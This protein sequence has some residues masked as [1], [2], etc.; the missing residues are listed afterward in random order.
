[1]ALTYVNQIG[2]VDGII[3]AAPTTMIPE[4]GIVWSRDIL[5]DRMGTLRRRGPLTDIN[6]ASLEENEYIAGAVST[7]DPQGEWRMAA[8][9][10]RGVATNGVIRFYNSSGAG[11][12]A[13]TL[14]VNLP[15]G[16]YRADNTVEQNTTER[17]ENPMTHVIGH[18]SLGS[19][20][21]LSVFTSYGLPVDGLNYDRFQSLFYW[22]GGA[23]VDCKTE[24]ANCRVGIEEVEAASA[25]PNNR[26]FTRVFT[27]NTSGQSITLST[28]GRLTPGMFVF[29]DDDNAPGQCIG[30]IKSVE[31]NDPAAPTGFTL[32]NRPM[33]AHR[34]SLNTASR[35]EY[36][37]SELASLKLH[38]RNVRGYMP[39]HGRGLISVSAG[40]VVTGGAE[41]TSTEGHFGA[42]RLNEGDVFVYRNSDMACIGKI[43]STKPISNE[44][45]QL[46]FETKLALNSDEYLAVRRRTSDNAS[47]DGSTEPAKFYQSRISG[48]TG[49]VATKRTPAD[50]P[51]VFTATY[52]GFQWYGSLGQKGHENQIAFSS[53]HN[54]EA[55]DLSPDA[56]DTIVIPGMNVMRGIATSSSGLVIFMGDKVYILRG[57]DRSNFSLEVL[58]PEGC[59]SASS[60][61]E[62]GGGVMWA[63]RAGILYFDGSSVRNLTADNWG[64]YYYD[65]V[66]GFD[67]NNDRC[68]SFLYKNY[69]FV[70][71]TRWSSSYSYRRKE[72]QYVNVAAGDTFDSIIVDGVTYTEDDYKRVCTWDDLVQKRYAITWKRIRNTIPFLTFAIYLP[73]G[74]ITALSNFS[75]SGAVFNDAV[76]ATTGAQ[77][78]FSKSWVAINAAK[79][80]NSAFVADRLPNIVTSVSKSDTTVT[81]TLDSNYDSDNADPFTASGSE[82]P[83]FQVGTIVDLYDRDDNPIVQAV[84]TG[85]NQSTNQVTYTL[86]SGAVP[87]GVVS[88]GRAEYRVT[89]SGRWVDIDSM[90]DISTNGTDDIIATTSSIPGPDWFLQ[91][92]CYTVGDPVIKKWFQRFMLSMLIQAGSVRVDMID[93]ENNDY[94]SS[95]LR[96]RNWVQFSEVVYKWSY[97]E[98]TLFKAITDLDDPPWAAVESLGETWQQILFAAFERRTKRFSLRLGSLGYQMYQLNQFKPADS[99]VRSL[100]QRPERIE[101]D[102]WSI[103]F[104]ALRA[105]RQ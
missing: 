34:L 69:L 101:S 79:R 73:T 43:D 24:N 96:Q 29:D 16:V 21:F 2:A 40:N 35:L 49:M 44:Q 52:A 32:E 77:L 56:A 100:V 72:P 63:S 19:G 4:S 53:Y 85:T 37:T 10:A 74:S 98:N 76:N 87:T 71:F 90:L 17:V 33:L 68:Y 93:A 13:T 48:D 59:M 102:A 78:D 103:G 61:V 84:L 82:T 12:A 47:S 1:M 41:G 57:N 8:V 54:P 62:V 66:K 46:T 75:F 23:G 99:G 22:R 15:N 45:F 86:L 30:V 18:E 81:V 38:F 42:A 83:Y 91:T 88:I 31:G 95:A 3:Q 94:V 11:L 36:P 89:N 9:I 50:V 26:Q 104:K 51:G 67:A 70:S 97:V 60:I 92:K 7:H 55:V 105:G 25:S 64:T 6:V 65:G 27:Q 14:P 20:A 5:L 28:N 80:R 39:M 58:Y